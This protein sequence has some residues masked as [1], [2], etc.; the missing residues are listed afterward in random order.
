MEKHLETMRYTL[1]AITSAGFS[2]DCISTGDDNRISSEKGAYILL[3]DLPL[4]VE[5][6]LARTGIVSLPPGIYIYCGSARGPGGLR[7]RLQHHFKKD[8]KPHWHIDRLTLKAQTV[9]ALALENAD[10]CELV[11]RLMETEKFMFPAPGFGS[12]D[13]TKCKSHLLKMRR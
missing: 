4:P 1:S 6:R 8:K 11:A 10:E 3:V 7:A 13:C 2:S 9:V 5:V 12:S